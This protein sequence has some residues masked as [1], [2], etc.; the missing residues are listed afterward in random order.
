[1]KTLINSFSGNTMNVY[2]KAT[3]RGSYE[4]YKYCDKHYLLVSNGV[5]IKEYAGRG[6]CEAFADMLEPVARA[7]QAVTRK[8]LAEECTPRS[9]QAKDILKRC[10]L[11]KP[12]LEALELM[13][14]RLPSPQ[15]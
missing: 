9:P 2:G 12:L 13:V 3:K 1:M 5:V 10:V 14:A 4:I 7:Q 15:M 8:L 6:G 11:S